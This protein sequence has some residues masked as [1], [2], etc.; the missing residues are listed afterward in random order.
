[1]FISETKVRVRYAET[2]KMGY[3]YYGNC[4]QYYEVGRV[5]ALRKLDSSYKALEDSGIMM[6][7]IQLI[8]NFKKP[9]LYDDILTIKTIIKEKPGVKIKF[10][11]ELYNE[12]NVLIN[13]G[14]T[15]LAFVHQNTMKPCNCPQ[16]FNDLFIDFDLKECFERTNIKKNNSV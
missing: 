10:Y 13:Q 3:V 12:M 11:Y 1:M 14:E 2:D 5:E 16:W 6:P 7:V 9:A 8:I 15:I 4:A